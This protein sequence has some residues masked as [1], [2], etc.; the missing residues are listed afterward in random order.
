[1]V[2]VTRADREAPDLL[3]VRTSTSGTR[4]STSRRC[5]TAQSRV[6]RPREEQA[7]RA[8][9][10]SRADNMKAFPAHRA[11]TATRIK[12]DAASSYRSRTSCR[13]TISTNS[14]PGSKIG[15][16]VYRRTL[17]ARRH[18]LG[19]RLVD[20]DQGRRGRQ[21]RDSVFHRAHARCTTPTRSSLQVK[22][23]R[24]RPSEIRCRP[25]RLANHRQRVAGER[26]LQAASDILLG[27]MRTTGIDGVERDYYLRQLW[28]PEVLGRDRRHVAVLARHLCPPG[29][30]DARGHARSGGRDRLRRT[31]APTMRS[32]VRWSST[33]AVSTRARRN[34]H[35][36][37]EGRLRGVDCAKLTRQLTRPARRRPR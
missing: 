15:I 25:E 10:A 28:D 5:S 24:G 13:A 9:R 11:S 27:W 14:A 3:G 17:P 12:A 33:A 34:R 7:V 21:R 30:M 6:R 18:L 4:D 31:R 8:E 37:T 22:E 20:F 16:R 36:R 19:R 32:S 29:R 1:M 2:V 23:G 35:E 26:L